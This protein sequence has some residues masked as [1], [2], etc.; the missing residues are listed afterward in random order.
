MSVIG[1]RIRAARQAARWSK[2][3]LCD[4]AVDGAQ[5]AQRAVKAALH[6]EM[7][8]EE[9]GSERVALRGMFPTAIT[10]WE[11]G[12]WEP[13]HK[14]LSWVAWALNAPDKGRVIT[15]AIL[16]GEEPLDLSGAIPPRWTD[17][18]PQTAEYGWT[19]KTEKAYD[20]ARREAES[21]E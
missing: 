6:E 1:E 20:A 8:L 2:Q 3:D 18:P 11:S 16:R 19:T 9:D 12:E 15:P 4:V 10:R 21:E 14:Q 7:P 17:Y 5:R 13:S